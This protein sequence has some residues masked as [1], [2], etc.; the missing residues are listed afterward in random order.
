MLFNSIEFLFIFLPIVFV[1]YFLLNNF[2]FY[3]ASKIW[4][5]IASLFF[6]AIYKFNYLHIIL[7]SVIFNFFM[8]K[9]LQKNISEFV[10]K[11]IVLAFTLVCNLLLLCYFKYFDFLIE[12]LNTNLHTQFNTMNL[13]LPLGISFFTF[14]QIS[15]IV[16]CY[17]GEIKDTNFIDYILFVTFFPQLVAGPIIQYREIV[18]QF[19]DNSK[20]NINSQNIS[21]GFFLITIGL[22]KKVLLADN[23]APF[24]SQ[25]LNGLSNLDFLNSWFLALSIGSQ[26]YFDF[27]GYCDMA[28]GIALLFNITIL[29]NFNSPYQSVDIS[30]FWRRWHI[31]LG[32]FMKY[33]VY[34]PLGGSR[35]GTLKTYRNLFF[36]FL[37][38]GVW[39]GANI[40]CIMYGVVNG[41]LVCFNKFWKSLKIEMNKYLAIA[42]TYATMIFICPLVLVK[43]FHEFLK[44]FYAMTGMQTVFKLPSVSEF[45]LVFNNGSALNIFLIS[46]SL[47][48]VLFV[49]NS[50]ELCEKYLK[51]N[52][53]IISL[54]VILL[55]IIST[56][57]I[58]RCPNEFIY[59]QF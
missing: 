40:P 41:I 7:S 9:I 52:K 59:F 51:G 14:Q 56:L 50:N 46:I 53:E 45:S 16:D 31:S 42:I 34:I 29:P 49:Q 10:N 22:A 30:D 32:K 24:I 11:K 23:F 27:S 57:C 28:L 39:H 44:V 36:V 37:L 3:T 6:Y 21:A 26:G 25:T 4:L 18:P 2:K 43:S 35:V 1:I 12:I 58:N 5:I 13:L 54:A 38:I 55:F 47:I 33:Y 8:G 20:K 19:Q 48:I 15:Y 17:K